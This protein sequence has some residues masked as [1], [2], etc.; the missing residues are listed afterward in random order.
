[1]KKILSHSLII[2]ILATIVSC[3][4]RNEQ[5]ISGAGLSDI[6]LDTLFTDSNYK[7][8]TTTID[9]MEYI[10]VFKK[11]GLKYEDVA[12]KPAQY[13]KTAD[14]KTMLIRFGMLCTDIAYM[15]IIGGK[16]QIPEYDRLFQRYLKDLNLTSVMKTDATRYFNTLATNELTDTL[17]KKMIDAFRLER[18][19]LIQNVQ[20]THDEDFL[21]YFSLGTETELM[22][23]M[24][25]HLK[26]SLNLE[27]FRDYTFYGYKN[28]HPVCNIYY[29]IWSKEMMNKRFNEYKDQ[30]ARLKPAYELMYQKN[31]KNEKYTREEVNSV[32]NV[33]SDFRNDI[34]K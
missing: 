18:A 34:L 19:L 17:Y 31:L 23:I 6:P 5:S 21:V 14:R 26:N 33:F 25:A 24:A 2:I 7:Y 16:S 32:V 22:H 1:M 11:Q 8:L 4:S 10:T 12:A 29:Q 20:N 15:K 30:L 13:D 9:F 28:G 3:K 27:V